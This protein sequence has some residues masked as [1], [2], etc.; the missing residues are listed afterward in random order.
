MIQRPPESPTRAEVPAA[1]R[2]AVRATAAAS[3]ALKQQAAAR[4]HVAAAEMR[5]PAPCTHRDRLRMGYV[6]QVAG[7]HVGRSHEQ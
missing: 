2:P 6:S 5:R 3:V 1:V 4:A 7:A